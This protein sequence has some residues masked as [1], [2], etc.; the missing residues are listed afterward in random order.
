MTVA[1]A[2]PSRRA[3]VRQLTVLGGGGIALAC[4]ETSQAGDHPAP[5][6]QARGDDDSPQKR[7]IDHVAP[8]RDSVGPAPEAFSWT[9]VP[10]AD[11][12]AIGIWNEVDRLMWRNDAVPGNSVPR[13]AGLELDPGTYFWSVSALQGGREIGHSGQAAFV[14]E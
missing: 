8:R 2:Q 5:A 3:F 6:A 1:H 13:P 9:A 12:Y 10:G 4:G 14:V 7:V 11:A